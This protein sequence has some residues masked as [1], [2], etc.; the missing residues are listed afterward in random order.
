MQNGDS[1]FGDSIFCGNTFYGIILRV[2]DWWLLNS[3]L[4]YIG[5]KYWGVN[6]LLYYQLISLTVDFLKHIIKLY[7]DSR[8]SHDLFHKCCFLKIRFLEN[9]IPDIPSYKKREE[10]RIVLDKCK[11]I[12]KICH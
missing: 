3:H 1:S 2:E 11:N 6:L 5:T 8:I 9:V 4:W 10:A 7:E 12:M